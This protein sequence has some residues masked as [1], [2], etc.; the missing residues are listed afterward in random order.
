M[1]KVVSVAPIMYRGLHRPN[2]WQ[3]TVVTRESNFVSFSSGFEAF[4][5]GEIHTLSGDRFASFSSSEK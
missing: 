1:V 2:Y 3:A 4:G 5:T